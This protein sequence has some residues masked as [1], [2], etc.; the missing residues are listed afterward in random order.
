MTAVHPWLVGLAWTLLAVG[1][2]TAVWNWLSD[3]DSLAFPIIAM[4]V[5]LAGFVAASAVV[6]SVASVVNPSLDSDGRFRECCALA[7]LVFLLCA[8]WEY[9]AD[10]YFKPFRF[11]M[12]VPAVIALGRFAMT[13]PAHVKSGAAQLV[14]LL[15][16]VPDPAKNALLIAT[17]LLGFLA[18]CVKLVKSFT[19]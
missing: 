5:R 18:A 2:L 1:L 12:W 11:L 8:I 6:G 14:V 9:A 7:M 16:Q 15:N 3:R 4:I 17:V 10:W 13:I 19:T